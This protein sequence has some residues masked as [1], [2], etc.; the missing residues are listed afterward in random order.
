MRGIINARSIVG[1]SRRRKRLGIRLRRW[2]SAGRKLVEI[3]RDRNGGAL[4]DVV[5]SSVG[6]DLFPRMIDLL[7][8]SGRLVFYG[9][10]S[11]YTLTLFGKTRAAPARGMLAR[12][13]VRAHA[14]VLV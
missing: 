10:T 13:A 5:V 6:R 11:G 12:A 1:R 7:A 4:I 8:P 3:V 2:L 14:G 9:A